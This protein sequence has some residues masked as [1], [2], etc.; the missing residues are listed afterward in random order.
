MDDQSEVIVK[1]GTFGFDPSEWLAEGCVA[2]KNGEVWT[3]APKTLVKNNDELSAAVGAAQ[4][5]DVIYLAEGE[6]D[7]KYKAGVKF[8]GSSADDVTIGVS[9][10]YAVNGDVAIENVTLKFSNANY[11][12]FQ[13][14]SQ[15]SYKNC[16]IIGQPFL[17]GDDVVFEGCTFEQ[18]S[19]GAYN[20][21]TYGAKN[22]EFNKC[23]FNCA[24][25]SVL[26]Y[27]EKGHVHNVT[28]NECVLNAS[29]PVNGK[30][31]VEIDS[32][33]PNGGTGHYTVNFISTSANGFAEGNVSGNSLWNN[34]K[35]ANA[36]VNV[37]GVTV[38]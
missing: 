38:L 32:S 2:T 3:V 34:K 10:G 36:T 31:A 25:K 4:A 19:A 21:W 35:G 17:Y 26:V 15:E 7:I 22:V 18:E 37:D 11:T 1:G 16:T 23:T 13:H 24:G 9:K 12:G 8:I 33:F 29:A 6:Y 27:N 14:T 28:F 30:A 5:G 20:V